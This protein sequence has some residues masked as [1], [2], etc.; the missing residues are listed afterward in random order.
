[1]GGDYPELPL[2]K[3]A[4]RFAPSG[5]AYGSPLINEPKDKVSANGAGARSMQFA[6]LLAMLAFL[7]RALACVKHS[8]CVG[9]Q[10]CVSAKCV[11]AKPAGG[12][13][14]TDEQCETE[15]DQACISGI[16]MVPLITP[17]GKKCR[18][19]SDCPGQRL[20]VQS[21]CVAAVTTGTT[22]DSDKLCPIGQTCRYGA[23]WVPYQK[24]TG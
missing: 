19:Y 3:H 18:T 8:D 15:L 20:C 9:Q 16:C 17:A 13:C 4:K 11:P 1:M 6:L 23:C 5:T 21:K 24:P 7:E 2:F 10:M 12:M 22:C 14:N